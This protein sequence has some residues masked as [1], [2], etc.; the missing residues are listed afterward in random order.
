MF[1]SLKGVNPPNIK[2]I[3][4]MLPALSEGRYAQF[5]VLKHAQEA[6]RS[7]LAGMVK[8]TISAKDVGKMVDQAN[9]NYDKNQKS[10]IFGQAKE[11]FSLIETG[12][13][14]T[15]VMRKQCDSDV[16]L[17]LDNGKDGLYNGKGISAKL[18]KGD[19]TDIDLL[20]VFPDLKHGEK[21]E[22]WKIEMTG[23][24][25]LK[26]LEYSLEVDNTT[27]WFY[28]F[29]EI[30]MTYDITAQPGSRV[31]NLMMADGSKLVKDKIY[32]IAVMEDSVPNNLI[33]NTQKTG[34]LIQDLLKESIQAKKIIQPSHDMRFKLPQ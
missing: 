1:S 24:D 15:D 3:Q 6:L 14:V 32:S 30:K 18:Y 13:F 20:R 7:A 10:V 34:I 25:L 5:P 19:I 23:E 16:A 22:L 12:N 28:Y 27:G 9:T 17:F 4:D 33:K 2:E 31:S 8:G 11:N 29:S 21:G 26:T